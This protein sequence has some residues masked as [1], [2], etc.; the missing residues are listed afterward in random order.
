M[1]DLNKRKYCIKKEG[2]EIEGTRSS[3]SIGS[4]NCFLSLNPDYRRFSNKELT[5]FGYINTKDRE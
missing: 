4:W 1:T 2:K 5:R 3:T